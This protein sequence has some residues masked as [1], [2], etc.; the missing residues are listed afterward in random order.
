MKIKEIK[1]WLIERGITQAEIAKRAGVS[2]TA[3]HYFC[4]GYMTSANIESVFVNLGC[5][6]ELL[7]REAA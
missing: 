1:K 5:P 7:E 6:K 4:K 3:V 2:Q